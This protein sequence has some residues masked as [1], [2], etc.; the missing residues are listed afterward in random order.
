M[1]CA[2]ST[3]KYLLFFFN[4]LIVLCGIALLI[5]GIIALVQLDDTYYFLDAKF[6]VPAIVVTS[7]GGLL[8]VIGFFGCCGAIKENNCMINTYAVLVVL[9]VI[10]ELAVG[11]TAFVYRDD[12]G[13]IL[14]DKLQNAV[15]NY[16]KDTEASEAINALQTELECCGAD[17]YKDYPT[18]D[19]PPSCC[20][21]G[22]SCSKSPGQHFATGCSVALADFIQSVGTLI[23]G[24]TIGVGVV[25]V[26]V[27]VLSCCLTRTIR[28]ER[29]FV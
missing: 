5:P 25:E 27:I 29:A 24:V 8:L 1:N 28:R 6:N 21:A 7:V 19:L 14:T 2:M 20:A 16:G 13:D 4:F 18:E 23:G 10:V 11:I 3:V 26:V 12:I 22:S 15:S 9:I 17:S